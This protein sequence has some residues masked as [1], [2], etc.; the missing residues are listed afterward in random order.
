[1]HIHSEGSP[2]KLLKLHASSKLQQFEDICTE[3]E[4]SQSCVTQ[5]V[6]II[7]FISFEIKTV[8]PNHEMGFE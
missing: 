2:V 3:E 6:P 5:K 1:M 8:F 7:I 4:N